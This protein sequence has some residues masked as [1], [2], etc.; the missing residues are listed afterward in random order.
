MV[1]KLLE[2]TLL[3]EVNIGND[4]KIILEEINLA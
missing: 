4:H 2:L 1:T 3:L